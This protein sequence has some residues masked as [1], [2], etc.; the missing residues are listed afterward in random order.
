MFVLH[1]A[2]IQ[3]NLDN[4]VNA[5]VPKHVAEQGKYVTTAL[6]NINNVKIDGVDQLKYE[7]AENF[8]GYL[9][10]PYDRPDLVVFHEVNVIEYISLYKRLKKLGIP[11]IIVPHGEIT[12]QALKKKWLKKKIAYFLWFNG[13]IKNAKAIQCLSN[14]EYEESKTKC[15]KFISSNGTDIPMESKLYKG[16]AGM[17]LLYIGRLDWI[18]KG[19]D[20]M[21]NA[22]G[23]I[24]DYARDNKITLDI[25]GPDFFGRR[26]KIESIIKENHVEDIVSVQ[27]SVFGEEKKEIILNH[28]V[29]I[30]TSRFEGQPLGILEAMSF[31]MVV[32][33][34]KGTN[35][36]EN[37]KE[38]NGG[39][40]AGNSEPEIAGAIRTAFEGKNQWAVLGR[41]A[42]E[43]VNEKYNWEAMAKRALTEYGRYIG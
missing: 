6:L 36:V 21:I 4:G 19:I 33:A 38:C 28:D 43:F 16:E 30:Q 41:N 7:G 2:K 31:G 11:Y 24:Q 13:F 10:A 1:I 17:R 39:Y 8:P 9:G 42:K 20:M 40:D 26:E 14:G 5:V 25:Y 35:F 29:F 27:D 34:T 22:I 32:I 15:R 18:H 3:T 37:I 23:S 12:E